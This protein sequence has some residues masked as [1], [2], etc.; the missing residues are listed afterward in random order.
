M[1]ILLTSAGRR[2]YL[3]KYFR[4]AL[5]GNGQVHVC[6]S[7]AL[8]TAF[9]AADAAVVSPMIYSDAYIP[10]LLDYCRQYRIDAVIPLFDPDLPVLST[11]RE[12]FGRI[13]ATVI[14]SRPE[15][16]AVCNDKWSTYE[17]LHAN[18]IDTPRSYLCPDDA[19]SDIG[20]G[21]LSFP[22]MV[23]P[24]WGMGSIAVYEVENEEEL[25]VIYQKVRREVFRTYLQY[26]SAA[27]EARCVL[28][29]EKIAGEEYGLDV[30]NDL[31]GCYCAT[32]CKRKWGMRSGETDCAITVDAPDLR[33]L[34]K[35]LSEL[36]RHV[37]NL[38]CD[39]MMKD[40]RAWVLEMNARFGGG[41]PF[42]H[43]AGA[44]LPA[45]IL[46]WLQGQKADEELMHIRYGVAAQ[47][48][49]TPM[50][51]REDSAMRWK[52]ERE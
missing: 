13:G 23:K 25:R 2:S 32:W 34:G 11:H 9:E 44:N 17:F 50:S 30:V 38:D 46:Q 29:Q 27:D 47:K 40:G 52:K 8:S 22:L 37:A 14:V 39:V 49:I 45:A 28:I 33:H 24:R 41:Y 10:F 26:E 4:R 18:G 31:N 16:I 43:V 36:L 7:T 3:V 5:N 35:R 20:R 1:N 19:L 51:V 15:A 6:N 42:S 12:D 48:D 21:A